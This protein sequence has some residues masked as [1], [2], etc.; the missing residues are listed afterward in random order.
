MKLALECPTSMLDMIQPF[1][2]FDFVLSD[3]VLKDEVYKNYYL[4][5]R[6]LK[7]VD[8]SVN[9][10][11]EPLDLDKII[12]AF[13]L[14]KGSVLIPPDYLGDG[15]KTLNS[16]KE[17]CLYIENP[18]NKLVSIEVMGVIQGST[19]E[20]VFSYIPY[21]KGMVG[22][23]YDICSL[24]TDPPWLMGLRRA[25]VVNSLPPELTIHL[26]GFS[27]LDELFWYGSNPRVISM[28]TGIPILL[29]LNERDILEPLE[30]K[31]DPTL[32]LMDK[33][34]LTPKNWTAI[35]R[36]IALLRKYLS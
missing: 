10:N 31:K 35:C 26:L 2:D 17:A 5:S 27:S 25:L 33:I 11:G 12:K 28:D 29:G 3:L 13:E 8:N 7:I 16:Y 36:N 15:Q 23:P 34:E 14:V 4:E 9:E 1:A 24:K 20:E 30:S 6:K 22:V 19:F 32:L 18:R 21:Y